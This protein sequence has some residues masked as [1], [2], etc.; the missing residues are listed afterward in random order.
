MGKS[1][2]Q[3]QLSKT[4]VSKFILNCL[5]SQDQHND[6]RTESAE[7]VRVL[8]AAAKSNDRALAE[9]FYARRIPCSVRDKNSKRYELEMIRQREGHVFIELRTKS[10][11]TL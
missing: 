5:P 8:A 9:D 7:A 1:K 4:K 11:L 2:P 3:K 10:L 6:W